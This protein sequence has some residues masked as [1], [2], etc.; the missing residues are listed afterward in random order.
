MCIRVFYHISVNFIFTYLDTKCRYIKDKSYVLGCNFPNE[1]LRDLGNKKTINTY[2]CSEHFGDRYNKLNETGRLQI[3]FHFTL[4]KNFP[5]F[6]NLFDNISLD[7]PT[8]KVL[9]NSHNYRECRKNRP[10]LTRL[11]KYK[12]IHFM[13]LVQKQNAD[14]TC[15][16]EPL[17]G[18]RHS[19]PRND[20]RGN[21]TPLSIDGVHC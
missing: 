19:D 3:Y 13:H 7:I 15:F 16:S 8:Y 4:G 6:S 5:N 20:N 17:H 11:L 14:I 12:Y 1:I 9:R 2:R 10:S 21:T 18:S